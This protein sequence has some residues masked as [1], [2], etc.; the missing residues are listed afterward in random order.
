MLVIGEGTGATTAAIQA[1]RSGAKTI[2][3]TPLPWLG[4]MLTS[5]GVSAI[6]GNHQLPSGLWG[7]FRDSLRKYYGSAEALSTG[8][9]SY[10][11]FE[12][13]V[14]AYYWKQMAEKEPNLT[15]L[16]SA[17]YTSIQKEK[18]WL[19]EVAQN[20]QKQTISAYILIDGTDLGDVAAK[21]GVTYD[22]GMDARAE[23]GETMAPEKAND[24]IQDLTYAVILKDYGTQADKTIAKP[25][26]YNAAQFHCACQ[27]HCEDTLAKPHPCE[28][29]LTY[30]KLP[31]N[32]YMINWPIKGNDYYVNIIELDVAARAAALEKAKNKTLQFVYYLQTELGFNYLGIADDEFPTS[33]GLA[34]MPYHREG[35]RTHGLVQLNVNHILQPYDYNLYRTGIAVGD[36]PI[37]HHH[38]ERPDAPTI[39]FPKVPSF[40]IPLGALIPKDIDHLLVADKAISVTNIVNGASRLQP[41]VIQIGQVAG[42]VAAMAVQ[43]QTSP[44]ALNV[45][46]IQ[47]NLLAI[48]GYLLPFIDVSPTHP[49]FETIQKIG[50]TGWLQGRGVPYKW[51]N[52][53]WFD[54]DSTLSL[55][56]F[57]HGAK[58]YGIDA[59]HDIKTSTPLTIADAIDFLFKNTQ[60]ENDFSSSDL[61]TLTHQVE[62][63]WT[64][65]WQLNNF[66]PQRPITRIELAVLLDKLLNPWKK[67]INSA[68]NWLTRK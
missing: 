18:K 59:S 57:L 11:L 2:L 4:G 26:G 45:R 22:V 51:A 21:A 20:G 19:V 35:R 61:Q 34:L 29:M 31:N 7:E 64:S 48:D 65:V 32:K 15:I 40:S 52:Q 8:W 56:T 16:Y 54:P 58:Q 9:V 37:D 66:E 30:A 14:G 42:L 50:A 13:H 25:M 1:A 38:Y 68:G 49:H 6:D 60:L 43:T 41:V 55:E 24:I 10:T 3:V 39:D 12:P 62:T 17:T 44:K 33:D 67:E 5:A 47:E 36:Y 46:A 27:T 28:T 63:A 53:T 23:T